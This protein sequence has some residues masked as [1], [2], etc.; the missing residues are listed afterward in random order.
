LTGVIGA[1]E[2]AR[3][4]GVDRVT[5]LE[6]CKKKNN[7]F[8]M[9]S[10]IK[11]NKNN[12]GYWEIPE[13]ALLRY[14]EFIQD[15]FTII[16]LSEISGFS[17]QLINGWVIKGR[18]SDTKRIN[19]MHYIPK[20]EG[21]KIINVEKV[22][23][24]VSQVGLSRTSVINYI[25]EGLFPGAFKIGFVWYIPRN[26]IQRFIE[27]YYPANFKVEDYFE[28]GE[29]A[30]LLGMKTVN[31]KKL[32]DSDFFPELTAIK[33]G[34]NPKSYIRKVE[35]MNFIDFLKNRKRDYYSLKQIRRRL[36]CSYS[37]AN[38]LIQQIK[39]VRW[40]PGRTVIYQLVPKEAFNLMLST[41]DIYRTTNLSDPTAVFE[42]TIER[43][44]IPTYLKQSRDNYIHYVK[45]RMACSQASHPKQIADARTYGLLFQNLTTILTKEIHECTDD[46]IKH[47][48]KSLNAAKHKTLFTGFLDSLSKIVSCLFSENYKVSTLPGSVHSPKEIYTLDQFLKYQ[49]Y[50]MNVE[51]HV[52]FAASSR[53]YAVVWLF[54]SLHFTNAWRSADF[55]A[56]PNLSTNIVSIH[57]L[58]YFLKGG[59]LKIKEAQL[60]INH[61]AGQRFTVSK[62]G[63]LNRFLIN[64]D[65]VIPVA[66]MILICDLHRQLMSDSVLLNIGSKYNT[67]KEQHLRL[68]FRD[69]E[70]TFG[71][72]KMN[73]TFMT[74]LFYKASSQEATVGFALEM[75]RKTRAHKDPQN[76]SIY[77]QATNRDGS[78][79]NTSLHVCNRGHFG[80][81]YNLLVETLSNPKKLQR[82]MEHRT[83][84]ILEL[85]KV[86]PTPI[87][88]QLFGDFL[89]KQYEEQ[90]SL[91]IRIAQTPLEEIEN[92]LVR[93]YEDKM[94]GHSEFV[95]CYTYPTC[96]NPNATSC[97]SCVYSV[98]KVYLLISLKEELFTRLN[99]LRESTLR[100][101]YI[102]EK[103]LDLQNALCASM[104]SEYIWSRTH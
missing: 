100:G 35:V 93:I 71:S 22:E 95:Q 89:S 68:V 55:M 103:K 90:D 32:L 57:S 72:R 16:Q 78:I 15:H 51:E 54:A 88:L 58:D 38:S 9:I 75:S 53:K 101:V 45:T 7:P 63:A 102:R 104:G 24:I 17:R 47:V 82:T 81:L 65:V 79:D 61:Y 98:P 20:S 18:F 1:L 60:I 74:Y 41:R 56:L 64:S 86:F 84:D 12:R 8:E 4:L 73:R 10:G 27:Q 31:L 87:D 21:E 92:R 2:A 67:I 77:I 40:S 3:I 28:A 59:R 36:N 30:R 99:R 37:Y 52:I 66:T 76:T 69:K 25:N 83:N 85:K 62:T 19:K 33:I 39:G 13:E 23:Y 48:F 29:A 11:I 6:W 26:D 94:P 5:V 97:Y 50:I 91:A 49:T 96:S 34:Y 14:L 46:D 44:E 70:F 42:Y 43:V 80:Y